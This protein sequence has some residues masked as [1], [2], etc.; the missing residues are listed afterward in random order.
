MPG[1]DSSSV[2]T[3]GRFPEDKSKYR[4]RSSKSTLDQEVILEQERYLSATE[5]NSKENDLG[6]TSFRRIAEFWAGSSSLH[7]DVL[8]CDSGANIPESDRAVHP[9]QLILKES[10]LAAVQAPVSRANEPK[11]DRL[12]AEKEFI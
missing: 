6:R 12:R 2:S 7:L 10:C 4:T 3:I 5:S 8:S 11:R 9:Y 1:L